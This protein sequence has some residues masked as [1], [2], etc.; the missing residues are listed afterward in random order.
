MIFDKT[1]IKELRYSDSEQNIT[2][3]KYITPVALIGLLEHGDFK[4]TRASDANDLSELKF[5][6]KDGSVGEYRDFGFISLSKH[7]NHEALWGNY[8]EKY[9]GACIKLQIPYFSVKE[10]AEPQNPGERIEYEICA[11]LRQ[12]DY[13]AYCICY[14]NYD[15]GYDKIDNR[16]GD[17]LIKCFYHDELCVNPVAYDAN[18][19]L[20]FHQSIWKLVSR[21]HTNWEYE[22]E[23]RIV[24]RKERISRFSIGLPPM[25]FSNEITRF[26][27]KITLGPHC[28]IEKDEVDFIIKERRK[29][30]SQ[31]ACDFYIPDNVQIIKGVI[32]NGRVTFNE[33]EARINENGSS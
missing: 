14:G 30:M 29:Q 32:E 12:R 17:F 33:K 11:P 27:S 24:I 22:D 31:N 10:G 28:R 1:H 6:Y 9:S 5:K 16:G 25:F 2:L 20:N 13:E 7:E 18:D 21:K 4:L 19:N 8:A 3:Y 15:D 23:Y 26:I